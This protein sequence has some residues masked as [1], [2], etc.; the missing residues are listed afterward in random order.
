MYSDSLLSFVLSFS[1]L[2]HILSHNHHHHRR[3][4]A[5]YARWCSATFP[6][7]RRR[8]LSLLSLVSVCVIRLNTHTDTSTGVAQEALECLRESRTVCEW[9]MCLRSEIKF[10]E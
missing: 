4:R 7:R 3:N 8:R 6:P 1:I 9:E 5:R 2:I 10:S